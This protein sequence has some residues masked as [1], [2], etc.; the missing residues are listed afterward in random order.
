VTTPSSAAGATPRGGPPEVWAGFECTVRR[1][2]DGYLDQVVLTG[3]HDRIEDLDL[4]VDLGV[5][6]VR[7]PVLW[8]RT[9]PD[10]PERADWSWPDARLGR[11]RELGIEPIV[12]LVHHGSGPRHTSLVEGSFVSGLAAFAAAVARRYPWLRRFTPVNEP[13][14]TARFSGLYGHWYPHGRD[15]RTFV[16]ALLV[17]CRA[18]VEAMAAIRRT[19]PDAELVQTE[20]VGKVFATPRL[21]YQADFENERRWLSLDLLSGR[22]ARDHPL[23]PYLIDAGASERELAWFLE[24]RAPPDLIGVNHYLSGE[25]F[26]DERLERYPPQTHGGNGREAYADVVAAR[27]DRDG[28]AGPAVILREV[29]ARY[30]VPFAVTEAHNGCTREEQLRW[31][32]EVWDAAVALRAEGVDAV[33]VTAWSLLG[34]YDWA[35]LLTRDDGAYEVGVY[36][37]A[38]PVPRP[39]AMAA[40]LRDLAEGREH[41]HPVLATPGWWR[42]RERLCYAPSDARTGGPGDAVPRGPARPILIAGGGVLARTLARACEARGLA[43]RRLPRAEVDVADEAQVAAA[44]TALRPWAVINATGFG[45]VDLAEREPE[46][47][48]RVNARGP[49]VLAAACER[50]GARL[51]TFSSGLVFDGMHAEPYLERD[52]VA[53]LNVYG[54]AKAEGERHVLRR[55]GDAMVVRAGSF[56]GHGAERGFAGRTLLA[57]RRGDEVRVPSDLVVSPTYVPDLVT[58]TLDLLIDGERG[59]WHLAN[60]GG[61]SWH[62][63]A[64]MAAAQAGWDAERIVPCVGAHLAFDA[65]RPP[66]SVLASERANLVPPLE[67]AVARYLRS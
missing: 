64:T 43:Y 54:R 38:G 65:P 66:Y 21:A 10:G 60:G 24:R 19:I 23:W 56:F 12:G 40:M 42:R 53:P 63:F 16:R 3:H 26:L 33:A 58:A 46:A 61:V 15:D 44:L 9:A 59:I 31:F 51:V 11:L 20:D 7:Y 17:Q 13:L 2:G 39:T 57:L 4:L 48:F 6:T 29:W 25:R 36:D 32:R 45:S 35:S 67:D 49:A 5:R 22:L 55:H 30:G 34:A 27:V 18:T 8:T 52:G 37:V 1:V 41:D 28:P 50:S 62:D 14:T 47:C